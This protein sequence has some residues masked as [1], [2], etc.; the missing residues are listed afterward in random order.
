MAVCRLCALRVVA[1]FFEYFAE[2]L[3]CATVCL[4]LRSCQLHNFREHV[5]AQWGEAQWPSTSIPTLAPFQG[6]H[7]TLG[8][9]RSLAYFF[10]LYQGKNFEGVWAF[11][12]WLLGFAVSGGLLKP[13]EYLFFSYDFHRALGGKRALLKTLP[14]KS[15]QG[16]FVR[17]KPAFHGLNHEVAVAVRGAGRLCPVVTTPQVFPWPP[18]FRRTCGKR[19]IHRPFAV[20]QQKGFLPLPNGSA[21]PAIGVVPAAAGNNSGHGAAQ[22]GFFKEF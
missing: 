22:T 14:E 4:T 21:K 3:T 9:G 11:V 18:A 12:I 7:K 19:S 16:F 2:S 6:I 8:P 15:S 1:Y 13:S 17:Q 20:Y 5:C 10:G